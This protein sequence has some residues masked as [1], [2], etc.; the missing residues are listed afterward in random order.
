MPEKRTTQQP[1]LFDGAAADVSY[2]VWQPGEFND[3]REH[4]NRQE[5]GSRK[6][7]HCEKR[8]RPDKE[9]QYGQTRGDLVEQ[10]APWDADDSPS[11]AEWYC[12]SCIDYYHDQDGVEYCDDCNRY[13]FLSTGVRG[14]FKTHPQSTDNES[15]TCVR[16]YQKFM[17]EHGHHQ[18]EIDRVK[19]GTG[20]ISC[21]FYTYDELRQHGFTEARTFTNMELEDTKGM[22]WVNEVSAILEAGK[23]IVLTDQG[24]TNLMT[25]VPV[26]VTLWIKKKEQEA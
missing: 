15:L 25:G 23:Y 4:V 20:P 5:W 11:F 14:N 21:D 9:D 16:C 19:D 13:V 22:C 18:Q 2:F 12:R 1:S 3:F 26:S 7:Y 10:Y 6:C 17:F 24:S 8:F